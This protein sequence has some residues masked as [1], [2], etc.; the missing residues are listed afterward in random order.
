[1]SPSVTIRQ[2]WGERF[3][4]AYLPET[5]KPDEY[6]SYS[7]TNPKLITSITYQALHAAF[8]KSVMEAEA[9]EDELE[10]EET[11]DFT[12]FDIFA[13]IKKAGIKTICLDEAHHLKSE[14][15][16][17]L[18]KFVAMLGDGVTIIALTATPPYDSAPAEW[19]RYQ[20]LCGDIDEEIFVPQLVMQKTLCPHQDYIYFSYPT[21][22]E[23]QILAN[24]KAKASAVTDEI[25]RSGLLS[26]ALQA[27]DAAGNEE[28]LYDNLAGFKSLVCVAK[29]GNANISKS[30]EEKV[31][32]G[33]KAPV[34]S[35]AE[36]EKAFQFII[37]KPDI[38]AEEISEA[39]KA[40]LSKEALIE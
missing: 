13:E 24:Y 31:F 20:T 32:E 27:S 9:D 39:L 22:E 26:K 29:Q 38:F 10:T 15:Q 21:A 4:E 23:S 8:T 25:I 7:L 30:L 28:I 1:M 12:G 6:I 19:N 11:Q 3:I 5:E 16:K 40:I 37:D 36:A 33:R 17:A 2:Q 18:E 35:I 14:W 34:Y